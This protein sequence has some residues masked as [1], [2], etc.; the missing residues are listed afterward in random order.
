MSQLNGSDSL[1]SEAPE[2]VA[3]ITSIRAAEPQARPLGILIVDDDESIRRMLD[4]GLK[5]HGFAVW[6]AANA[7]EAI[8]LYHSHHQSVDLVLLDV[9]MPGQDGPTTLSAL[10]QRNHHIRAC[11]M[12][13]DA[14]IYTERDL[15]DRGALAVFQKPFHPHELAEQLKEMTISI[16]PRNASG[17]QLSS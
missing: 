4:I 1:L 12:T 13:G 9:R 7:N 3:P 6:A 14:G 16:D 8:D 10:Q 11:F 2:R 15:R 5:R 17:G